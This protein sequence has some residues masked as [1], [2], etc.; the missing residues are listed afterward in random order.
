MSAPTPHYS[1][2]D[3]DGLADNHRLAIATCVMTWAK[4]ESNLRA[5]LTALEGR[6]LDEG[7]KE[8][9]RLN[10]NDAWTKIKKLVREKGGSTGVL[11]T[12]QSNRDACREHYDTRRIIV[13]AGCVGIWEEDRSVM[14]FSAFEH[15]SEGEMAIYFVPLNDLSLSSTYAEAATKLALRLLKRLGH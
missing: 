9:D 15:Y 2:V 5:L 10:P 7:A 11:D 3:P 12:I 13:H 6:S 8:Y 14:A 4:C 1:E